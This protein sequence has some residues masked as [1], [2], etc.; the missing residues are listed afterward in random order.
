MKRTLLGLALTAI[1]TSSFAFQAQI[2]GDFTYF[3]FDND[4]IDTAGQFDLKGTYYLAPV[5]NK[6]GPLNEAAFLSHS[7]NVYGKYTYNYVDTDTFYDEDGKNSA[8]VDIHNFNAGIEYFYEQFYVNGELGYNKTKTKITI[9]SNKYK[10][11]YNATTYRALVGFM[12][13]ENL[14]LAVGVDGFNGDLDDETNFALKAKFVTPVGQAGQFINLEA[15]GSFGDTD[16][17]TVGADYY[18]NKAFSV[19]AAYNRKDDG[20]DA[21]DFFSIRTKYFLNDAFAMGGAIGF[22]DDIKTFNVNATYRF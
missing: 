20:D 15:D 1:T 8:K 16:N 5:L 9:D 6:N 7:S 10:N 11:D 2:D 19:G 12:P 21:V 14:L 4:A 22:G 17:I 13:L 18:L 3:D